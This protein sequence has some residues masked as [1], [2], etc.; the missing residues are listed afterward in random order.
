M[1]KRLHFSKELVALVLTG[2]KNSTWRL[3]D[4]KNLQLGDIVD[5]YESKTKKYFTTAKITK[6]IEK[7]MGNLKEEDKRGHEEFSNDE[8]MY[9]T[10]SGYY[11]KDVTPDTLVKICWFELLKS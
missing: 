7:K 6:V 1:S 2:K 9:R 10:Y 4:D 5:F 3:W 8:E 11:K